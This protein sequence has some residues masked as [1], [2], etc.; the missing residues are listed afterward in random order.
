MKDVFMETQS[1]NKS[2]FKKGG[3]FEG[4]IPLI[5]A[6][7]KVLRENMTGAEMVLWGYL[8]N[9]IDGCK[10]RRQ[11]HPI[12]FY[13]A[14]FYCHKAKLIIEIDGSIHNDET[15]KQCDETG[16][17]DVENPGYQV[18]RFTNEEV[19]KQTE[20]VLQKIKSLINNRLQK[21]EG[22]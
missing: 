20:K 8:K 10:I 14:D 2:A 15:V 9:R 21:P 11:Q 12:G 4:A 16:Q 17:K 13:I 3:M 6:N 18:I 5:F 1:E 22:I 19:M 7:A